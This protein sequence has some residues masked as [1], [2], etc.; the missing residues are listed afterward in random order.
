[1][2]PIKIDSNGV[3]EWLSKKKGN[4]VE[5][6]ERTAKRLQTNSRPENP[7]FVFLSQ[8]FCGNVAG[9]PRKN[10]A[11]LMGLPTFYLDS[12]NY[13]RKNKYRKFHL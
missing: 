7:S 9:I 3:K 8:K 4:R 1:M 5:N 12:W 13:L 11:I 10:F 2:V 6:L